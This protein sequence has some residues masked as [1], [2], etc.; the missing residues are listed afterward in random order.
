MADCIKC[1]KEVIPYEMSLTKKL[2][3]RGTM[4]YMCQSCLAAHL[5]TTEEELDALALFF[6]KTGCALF[7][8][9]LRGADMFKREDIRIRD[10]F[11][12]TDKANKKYYM[13]GT[14]AFLDGVT[15]ST[16]PTFSAYVSDDLENFEGP[17]LIFDGTKENFWA[18]CDYWAPEVHEYKGK[19]YLFGSF[20]SETRPRGTQILV[21]DHPLGPFKPLTEN[22]ATP[23]NHECLDGTLWIEDGV[24]YLVYSHE[25]LQ[26]YDGEICAV[27]LSDDLKSWVGEPFVLFRA[28]DH[29]DVT[30]HEE[31]D[32]KKCYVTDGPFLYRE[33]GKI[34]MIWSSFIHGDYSVLVAQA[35]SIRGKWEHKAP[36]FDFDGG[37]SM[38]FETLEG[39]KKISLHRPNTLTKER[40]VFYDIEIK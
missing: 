36:K 32:G 40:A 29:P 27:Q 33:G 28:S 16:G 22:P 38:I 7:T 4:Q 21:A 35:D 20:K 19:Y 30:S 15:Y 2:I 3:N 13:Y 18:T 9:K 39:Q 12:L 17:Y 14:T 5:R 26:I 34:T 10:P 11:I 25:W 23:L 31:K 1:G 8:M 6:K 24:P 37:H